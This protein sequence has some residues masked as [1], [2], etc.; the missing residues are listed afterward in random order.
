[1]SNNVKVVLNRSAVRELLQS[2]AMEA[3]VKEVADGVAS[4]AGT[5]YAVDTR[6]GKNRANATISAA[7]AAAARD[8]AKN[9]TLLKAMGK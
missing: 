1:M 8:N 7:S 2:N 4:R 9:N 6:K 5:G 3:A